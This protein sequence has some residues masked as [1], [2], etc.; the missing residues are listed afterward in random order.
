[1][2]TMAMLFAFLCVW[3]CRAAMQTPLRG[4]MLPIRDCVESD[5]ATLHG[6]KVTLVRYQMVRGWFKENDN[7][8]L[9][10]FDLWLNERL[11]HL[12]N[13]ILPLARKYGMRVVVDLHVPPGGICGGE[14]N[15][16][17]E[18]KWA[19]HFVECW[20]RIAKRFKQRPEIYGFDLINEPL[21][22]R[23]SPCGLDYWSVQCR[24]AEAVRNIDPVTPI[25]VESN[26]R[27][28]P[29]T[30]VDMKPL[31]VSNV[32]Y[33]VHMYHP[34]EYTHQGVS[35]KDGAFE[36]LAYPNEKKGWG[37]RYLK[38]KLAPVRAFQLKHGVKVYVGEFSAIAWA[39]GADRFLSD[40]I[41]IFNEYGWDWT[42][43]AFRE[44]DGWS[45]EHEG[46]D[47]GHL[48]PAENT[49]RK[50][51]LLKGLKAPRCYE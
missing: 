6:W 16:F 4:V 37:K 44:W 20:K 39:E 8:D 33:Q 48:R 27:S 5:F 23:A 43:H 42:Y 12:E 1:M 25:I 46:S 9:P 49:S 45:V 40:C 51:A 2:K 34:I 18:R 3:Q 28:L 38:D 17:H 21:Q 30:Y 7:Q 35:S 14:M 22:M 24:A 32:I 47:A 29:D 19:D 15:M 13:V 41:S 36:R 31:A 50:Q 11:E 10:E 26:D